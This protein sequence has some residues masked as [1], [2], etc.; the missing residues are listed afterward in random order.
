[1]TSPAA[2][3]SVWCKR[4][5][6][7]TDAKV[8]SS[9][10][11]VVEFSNVSDTVGYLKYVGLDLWKKPTCVFPDKRISPNVISLV[12]VNYTAEERHRRRRRP[13]NYNRHIATNLRWKSELTPDHECGCSGRAAPLGYVNITAN[14]GMD[15]SSLTPTA[16]PLVLQDCWG[17]I[18]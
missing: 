15:L 11:N 2:S 17:L 4:C 8:E 18:H 14:H 5:V 16:P 10:F 9:S 1:M 6:S 13:K 7:V 3:V 12:A